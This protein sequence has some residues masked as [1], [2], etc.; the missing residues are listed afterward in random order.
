M[1]Y[2]DEFLQNEGTN[3]EGSYHVLAKNRKIAHILIFATFAGLI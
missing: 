3:F 1:K 2:M